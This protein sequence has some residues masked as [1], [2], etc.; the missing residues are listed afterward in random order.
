MFKIYI[1]NSL[2]IF[3]LIFN[4]SLDVIHFNFF[5]Y[6]LYKYSLCFCI[7]QKFKH[8][9]TKDLGLGLEAVLCLKNNFFK[10]IKNN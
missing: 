7:E 2:H 3:Y 10:K 5:D 1:L 9:E 4:I 6:F 8:I